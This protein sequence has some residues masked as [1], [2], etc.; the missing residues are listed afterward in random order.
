MP[1]WQSDEKRAENKARRAER[2][3]RRREKKAAVATTVAEVRAQQLAD[4]RTVKPLQV[5]R[6]GGGTTTINATV[7]EPDYKAIIAQQNQRIARLGELVQDLYDQ[8]D[9]L[10]EQVDE[11]EE[12][13]T[14]WAGRRDQGSMMLMDG[15]LAIGSSVV[16]ALNAGDNVKSPEALVLASGMRAFQAAGS[17]DEVTGRYL[18]VGELA[19]TIYAYYDSEVGLES[20]WTKDAAT[21]GGD[22][23]AAALTAAEV[24]AMI[25]ASIAAIP[26]GTT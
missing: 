13:T 5:P 11:L 10:E 23:S 19:T 15:I 26:G 17:V 3:A 4:V 16:T 9:D 22:N 7:D 1:F 8:V 21:A 2:R 6:A 24:Q 18:Q 12:A 25:D 14:D 20:L